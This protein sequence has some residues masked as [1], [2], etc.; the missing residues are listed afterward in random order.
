DIYFY[1]GVINSSL[2]NYFYNKFYGESNT[3]LTADA[4]KNI[5]IPNL[6]NVD[7]SIVINN[8]KILI[9]K[10]G[11]L[12]LYTNKFLKN[13]FKILSID[14]NPS[15]KLY[16]FYLLDFDEFYNELSKKKKLYF[17]NIDE[18]EEYFNKY[19]DA[20][21]RIIYDIN[22][23]ENTINTFVYDLYGITELESKSIEDICKTTKDTVV[24]S[25]AY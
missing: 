12:Y 7:K 2:I 16:N 20:I 22:V 18:L 9:N 11:K 4:V 1:I 19:K 6:K 3:N 23:C 15:N 25:L 5:P 10:Y 21:N 14:N 24:T 13:V 8:S 17:K